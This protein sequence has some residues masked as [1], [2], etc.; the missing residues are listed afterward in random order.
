MWRQ[1][2]EHAQLGRAYIAVSLPIEFSGDL[3]EPPLGDLAET[4]AQLLS[5]HGR[6]CY[7]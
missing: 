5:K 1:S 7:T 3:R 2:H 4:S 6:L